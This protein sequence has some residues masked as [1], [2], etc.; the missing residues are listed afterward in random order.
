[1]SVIFT[2]ILVAMMLFGSMMFAGEQSVAELQ[3]NLDLVWVLMASV[4]VFLMQPGFALVEAGLT[5]AKNVVNIMFKNLMDFAIGTLAYWMVGYGIM[6]GASLAGFVGGS[7]FFGAGIDLTDGLGIG[8]LLF[9]TMFAATAATIVSGAMAER[10]NFKAYILYT[11]FITG[12][13]YPVVGHWIWGGGW[14][15]S[16]GFSDFAGSTVVHS[17][18]GWAALVGAFILGPRISKYNKSGESQ[19]IP[20]HNIAYVG[21]GVFLLWAGWFGFNAGSELAANMSIAMIAVVTNLAAA[22]G[23][24]AATAFTWKLFGKPD[25]SMALNGALAGLVGITAG[26][27]AV[28][29]LSAVIIG[30]VAGVLVVL[31]VIFID[32]VLKIDDPVGAISVHGVC[33]IWG[34]LAVGLFAFEGGL[35]NGGGMDL[36]FVQLIGVA[37]VFAWTVVV[38]FIVFKTTDILLDL[39]VSREDE[40][41]GLDITE[42]GMEGY[43]GFQFFANE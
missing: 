38:S 29:P 4:L 14:L 22:A 1:M 6:F 21:L 23:A 32:K 33:G 16:L 8:A 34:T 12:F 36:L 11:I 3:Q 18:G 41:K 39:R 10:T 7:Y 15:A 27:N 35:F 28:S 13:I 5:R 20:G 17:V 24:I 19:A 2:L 31:S 42:H 40:I 9:Q 30:L 43:A 37:S 25:L 26:C